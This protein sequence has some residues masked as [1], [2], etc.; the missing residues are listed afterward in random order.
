[1]IVVNALSPA[2]MPTVRGESLPDSER[3]VRLP[4]E[5]D[6]ANNGTSGV[7]PSVAGSF[8]YTTGYAG[9]ALQVDTDYTK[10]NASNPAPYIDLGNHD[11]LKFGADTDFSISFW[12]KFPNTTKTDGWPVLITNKNQ[13]SETGWRIYTDAYE[14]IRWQMK[15]EGQSAYADVTAYR[16]LDTNWHHFT[17][18][19]D[20]DGYARFYIDGTE[21]AD[22]A[23]NLSLVTGSVDTAL[24]PK[25]GVNASGLLA[26]QT[27]DKLNIH[28]D[29]M[30]IFRK[31]LNAAEVGQLAKEL[32]ILFITEH[33]D[34]LAVGDTVR[35]HS[36]EI[37]NS[38][39]PS[40]V[41]EGVVFSSSNPSAVTVNALGDVQAIAPGETTIT[42]SYGGLSDTFVLTVGA[43]PTQSSLQNLSA[44]HPR[45]IATKADFERLSDKIESDDRANRWF[46]N[47]EQQGASLLADQTFNSKDPRRILV[48]GMLYNL[49]EDT[50]YS[51]RAWLEMENLMA[52]VLWNPD[53]FLEQAARLISAS[54]AYDWFYHEWGAERLERLRTDIIEKGLI[55]GLLTYRLGN[56]APY[57]TNYWNGKVTPY[58]ESNNWNTVGNTGQLIGALAVGDE[59]P[60]LSEEI[61][62]S[63]LEDILQSLEHFNPHGGWFEG[64]AY[65]N[66]T[67][68]NLAWLLASLDT[69]LG[70]AN[71]PLIGFPGLADSGYFPIHLEGS[72]GKM[73]DFGDSG[74]GIGDNEQMFYLAERYNKAEL[75]QFQLPYSDAT[76]T[77]D[78]LSLLWYEP[79][80]ADGTGY[81][82]I[83]LDHHYPGIEIGSMRQSWQDGN[84]VSVNFKAGAAQNGHMDLDAGSFVL[85]ALGE[86]WFSDLGDRNRSEWP[87]FF[88]TWGPRWT[89]YTKRAEG[90]NTLVINPKPATNVAGDP[91]QTYVYGA[92]F[93]NYIAPIT[94]MESGDTYAFATMDLIRAYGNHDAQ[95]IK[96]G[97]ALFNDR[98]H[99]LVQDEIVLN[100]PGEMYTFLHFNGKASYELAEGG[101][102]AILTIDGKRLW[103]GL[104]GEKEED[105]LTVMD[106]KPLPT[107]PNPA[108]QYSKPG[109]ITAETPTK[110]L[111]VHLT[112]RQE[113][114]IALYI[115]P[116]HEGEQP[117]A[118]EHWPEIAPLSEWESLF[119]NTPSGSATATLM[120]NSTLYVAQSAEW[121]V[122]LEGLDVPESEF[123]GADFIVNYDTTNLEFA[124][125]AD[126]DG[127]LSLTNDAIQLLSDNFVVAGSAVKPAT[128]QI[129][130]LL[131]KTDDSSFEAG[132][133]LLK[134]IGKVKSDAAVG[135]VAVSM[136]DFKLAVDG[137][138]SVI[139]TDR[140]IVESQIKL[141]NK[142][143]LDALIE[144]A[145]ILLSGS[146]T[147]TQPGQ[148]PPA[149]AT[150]LQTAINAA[151]LVV[152]NQVADQKEVNT[153]L[154]SLQSAIDSFL[155]AAIPYPSVDKSELAAL[156]TASR[157]KLDHSVEGNKVGQYEPGSKTVLQSVIQSAE[158]VM[159]QSGATEAQVLQAITELNA[160]LQQFFRKIVSL[161]GNETQITIED[162]SIAAQYFGAK[163]TDPIWSEIG[164]ADIY[165]E[166]EITIRSIAAIAR[167]ILDNWLNE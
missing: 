130:I 43:E 26:N 29:E 133:E 162:L 94:H 72:S 66:Y 28:L 113:A 84:G 40:P 61:L 160:Q 39:R 152:A 68:I 136:S 96:R 149:A 6:T 45:L 58:P 74:H 42:A 163:H 57:A 83:E 89:Y 13:S 3:F 17:V 144:Q 105:R 76:A 129:R 92:D 67:W 157:A 44:E 107:S 87:S 106:A 38:R 15:V 54:F 5:G 1:M 22:K 18:T 95:S 141:A 166:N 60:Y 69:G 49:T 126:E 41:T 109:A 73:Y 145:E 139:N 32:P 115:V 56:D 65:W 81:V 119:G 159:G 135:S 164:Q 7:T 132:G 102:S 112:D 14:N 91:D 9:Q 138:S 59:L 137:Q 31:A 122:G 33:V 151:E 114:T 167:M 98:S 53:M 99:V 24:T 148:Y 85:D 82:D 46:N 101:K 2:A 25:V 108:I 143:L 104:I 150:A 80:G 62:N 78:P 155:D 125:S 27:R 16:A 51:E 93:R 121:T 79:E 64:Y 48:L 21:A 10:V 75:K 8:A 131:I 124:T 36:Y 23:V 118:A 55:P 97:L 120:G 147:G 154:Q 111:A 30:H 50:R 4:F 20:R 19:H 100:S 88:S 34:Y 165:D 153:A 77:I 116:L 161:A 86:R 47:L 70:E 156:I 52:E 103:V 140:A 71:N 142:T 128:G 134:L 63:G 12:F 90:H 11:D 123:N 127:I 146:D 37:L 35:L 117:P 158:T 110:K